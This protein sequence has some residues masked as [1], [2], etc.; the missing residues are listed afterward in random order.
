MKQKQSAKD[1]AFEK[2]RAKFRKKERR[3]ADDNF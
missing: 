1:L 3:M 2:E